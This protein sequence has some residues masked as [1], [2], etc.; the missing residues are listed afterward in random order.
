MLFEFLLSLP[1]TT[2]PALLSYA[3]RQLYLASLTLAA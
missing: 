3:Q 1:F 2:R